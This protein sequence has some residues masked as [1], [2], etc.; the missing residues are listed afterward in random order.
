MVAE[1]ASVVVAQEVL[2]TLLVAM[3]I[4]VSLRA[5][6]APLAALVAATVVAP[7]PC[8]MSA[9]VRASTCKRQPISMSAVVAISMP[10]A[11]E[12]I[13]HAS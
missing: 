7:G 13:S 11:P 1:E 6:I 4:A 5:R 10:F 9:V 2:A 12:G 8:R 3:E